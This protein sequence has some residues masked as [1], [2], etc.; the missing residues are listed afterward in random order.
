MKEWLLKS[1]NEVGIAHFETCLVDMPETNSNEAFLIATPRS[2][3]L[4]LLLHKGHTLPPSNS[5]FDSF[6]RITIFGAPWRK[7]YRTWSKPRKV[8]ELGENERAAANS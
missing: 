7:A 2:G 3:C 8:R 4:I 5:T 6:Q 1:G